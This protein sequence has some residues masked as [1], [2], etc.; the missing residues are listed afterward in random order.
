MDMMFNFP[1]LNA[2]FV[3]SINDFLNSINCSFYSP[4]IEQRTVPSHEYVHSL[5][6]FRPHIILHKDSK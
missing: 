3:I 4:D 6:L 5:S 1:F 2:I